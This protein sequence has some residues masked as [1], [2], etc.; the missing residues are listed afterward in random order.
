MHSELCEHKKGTKLLQEE[1][2]Q[3]NGNELQETSSEQTEK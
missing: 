3:A 2:T 1:K